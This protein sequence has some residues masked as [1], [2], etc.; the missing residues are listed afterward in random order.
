[1]FSERFL[2]EGPGIGE[3]EEVSCGVWTGGTIG[4][5]GVV[6]Q[7]DD[8]EGWLRWL[9]S[10]N[11]VSQSSGSSEHTS[12]APASRGESCRVTAGVR[13]KA[14]VPRPVSV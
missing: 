8:G 2:N 5:A 13:V 9:P 4:L 10:S 3:S 6:E 11:E 12:V 7:T 14:G 1:M